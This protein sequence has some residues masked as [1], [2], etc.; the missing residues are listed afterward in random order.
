MNDNFSYFNI[1][2]VEIRLDWQGICVCYW[3]HVFY[4]VNSRR[5]SVPTAQAIMHN[6]SSGENQRRASTINHYIL[7]SVLNA[8]LWL[9]C[10]ITYT[11]NDINIYLPISLSC[12]TLQRFQP[13]LLQSNTG[14]YIY[15]ILT[16]I[17][18][19]GRKVFYVL[20]AGMN[21]ELHINVFSLS[22][23]MNI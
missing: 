9:Y 5:H 7:L 12:E 8:R 14:K 11:V 10:V 22:S 15:S 6:T 3:S 2:M 13:Q 1:F 17:N 21:T 4:R 19:V 23:H 16:A 20:G 18:W